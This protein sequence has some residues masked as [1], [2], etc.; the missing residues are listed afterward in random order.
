MLMVASGAQLAHHVAITSNETSDH[1]MEG[2]S[3]TDET[4]ITIPLSVR[5]I[6]V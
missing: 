3:D 4:I 6:S 2:K 1:N 5:S